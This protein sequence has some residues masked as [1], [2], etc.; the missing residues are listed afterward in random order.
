[1]CSY[2]SATIR[3]PSPALAGP[4]RPGPPAPSSQAGRPS[5]IASKEQAHEC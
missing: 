4:R 3:A 5:D 1:M 2:A